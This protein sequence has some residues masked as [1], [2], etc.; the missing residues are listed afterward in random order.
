MLESNSTSAAERP[1][2][3]GSSGASPRHLP[4]R[5]SG[6]SPAARRESEPARPTP[7]PWPTSPRSRS[8]P[9]FWRRSKP[10]ESTQARSWRRT[11]GSWKSRNPTAPLRYAK[12]IYQLGLS[13]ERAL[14]L[15]EALRLTRYVGRGLA[16]AFMRDE[17]ALIADARS[18]L[19]E[20]VR[21]LL[22]ALE[23]LRAARMTQDRDTILQAIRRVEEVPVPRPISDRLR[24]PI[25]IGLAYDSV[26]VKEPGDLERSGK[27]IRDFEARGTA[28]L[29]MSAWVAGSHRRKGELQR[30]EELVAAGLKRLKD[31]PPAT[32]AG[33]LIQAA[34]NADAR[35]DDEL[36]LECVRETLAAT[37][38]P[39]KIT[40]TKLSESLIWLRQGRLP[41]AARAIRVAHE[42]CPPKD[43][44]LVLQAV[45]FMGRVQLARKDSKAARES[46]AFAQ[47]H[48]GFARSSPEIRCLALALEAGLESAADNHSRAL[49]LAD[50]ALRVYDRD[51]FAHRMRLTALAGT[52]KLTT[53]RKEAAG[54]LEGRTLNPGPKAEIKTWLEQ[55]G[56]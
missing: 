20:E 9:A 26:T 27:L 44:S 34:L 17:A 50:E 52:G 48:A 40:V 24:V 51:S 47:K 45:L 53:A 3:R 56:K 7:A 2:R 29:G 28:P 12:A 14:L 8:S 39:T 54:L 5:D 37:Q 55:A 16:Q 38:A 18:R 23:A 4:P 30:A 10:P 21:A 41:Q 19:P 33:H 6:S 31:S 49:T 1:P 25:S 35:G 32:R 15:W 42:F 11:C 13:Q 46:L 22:S 43:H 36:A